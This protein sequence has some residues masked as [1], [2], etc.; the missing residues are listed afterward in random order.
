MY[1]NHAL[2]QVEG[3]AVRL[4]SLA[5]FPDPVSFQIQCQRILAVRLTIVRRS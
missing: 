1:I 5:S 2:V 3:P 4:W